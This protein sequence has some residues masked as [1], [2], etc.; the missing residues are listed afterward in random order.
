MTTK[1]SKITGHIVGVSRRRFLSGTAGAIATTGATLLPE[2]TIA[3]DQPLSLE[4]MAHALHEI[5]GRYSD[6]HDAPNIEMPGPR[7]RSAMFVN[8][9]M[10]MLRYSSVEEIQRLLKPLLGGAS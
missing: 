8:G 2:Q 4:Q 3:S 1:I 5:V 9:T 7:L 6:L 10:E